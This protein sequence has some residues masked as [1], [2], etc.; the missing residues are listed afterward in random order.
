MKHHEVK[1]TI[2]TSTLEQWYRDNE[3]L[4]WVYLPNSDIRLELQP[5][6][7]ERF[8]EPWASQ[9][10]SPTAIR[11][12]VDLYYSACL[13]ERYHFLSIEEGRLLVPI[14][15]APTRLTITGLEYALAEIINQGNGDLDKY[16]QNAGVEM[17][18][19]DERE[20]ITSLH[21]K[22]ERN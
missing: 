21:T 3:T 17:E 22:S 6:L 8:S 19:L 16:L 15:K 1:V 11:V 7:D 18:L 9:F 4:A 10:L 20:A 12:H 5:N 13:I 14:P 2:Q